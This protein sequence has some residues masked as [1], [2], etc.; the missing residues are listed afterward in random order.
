MKT[1]WVDS[2]VDSMIAVVAAAAATAAVAGDVDSGEVALHE[3]TGARRF[4]CIE[5]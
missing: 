1:K 4:A 5:S 3:S 2:P